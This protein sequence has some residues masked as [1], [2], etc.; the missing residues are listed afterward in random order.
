MDYADAYERAYQRIRPLLSEE[1]ADVEVPTCPG[2][3]VKDVVAHN[4]GFFTAY[5]SGNPKE[6]FGPGWGDREVEA[7]RDRSLE[8]DITEW[9]D[10]LADP[11]DL[12][13][14]HLAAVAVSDVLAHEQDIRTAIN[15]PGGED[16]ENIV[17][18][19]EMGL[20]W[21]EKKAESEGLP[22]IRFVTEDIDRTVGQGKPA[23]TLKTSTLELFRTIHGR[24]T[25]DQV[26]AMP[27]E[28]D[29]ERWL[30]ALFLFG[31]AEQPVEG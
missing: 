21:L 31:P 14:S 17:P 9:S 30:P 6:A 22:A 11:G 27:W 15:Q 25:V 28:G 8:E 20:A 2:W 19:V 18:S 3:T 29:P 1:V 24:R 13:E 4:A 10:L 7:R 26:R 12:F 16:D 5:K 23:A